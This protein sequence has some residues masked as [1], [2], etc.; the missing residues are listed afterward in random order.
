MTKNALLA[1]AEILCEN[2]CVSH[3]EQTV[4]EN[5]VQDNKR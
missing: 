1:S 2:S 5:L 4:S 3:I